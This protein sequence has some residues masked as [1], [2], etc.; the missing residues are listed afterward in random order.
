MC[1]KGQVDFD[2]KAQGE[3]FLRDGR[4]VG[5]IGNRSAQG[6][7]RQRAI[8]RC[9]RVSHHECEELAAVR[10]IWIDPPHLH[11]ALRARCVSFGFVFAAS[12]H[13]GCRAEALCEMK[14]E[15]VRG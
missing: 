15:Q 2:R 4:A 12:A 14:T 3:A 9:G 6:Q 1:S 5:T 7:K 10:E 11:P 8:Q 13:L